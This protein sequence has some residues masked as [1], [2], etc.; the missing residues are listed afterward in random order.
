MAHGLMD[1][2]R[3]V[4]GRRKSK[5]D[6]LRDADR[7]LD[8]EYRALK[9]ERDT[10]ARERAKVVLSG[11]ES[12]VAAFDAHV[13]DVEQRI[14]D[15]ERVLRP[16]MERRIAEARVEAAVANAPYHVEGLRKAVEAVEARR[17]E[18][19]AAQSHLRTLARTIGDDWRLAEQHGQLP[20]LPLV[21]AE[22]QAQVGELLE[23]RI[24]RPAGRV[25]FDAREASGA[26]ETWT[27]PQPR[28][29]PTK[30][31]RFDARPGQWTFVGDWTEEEKVR[32][33]RTTQQRQ[34]AGGIVTG[35]R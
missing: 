26:R 31:V 13:R 16:A 30:F 2:V 23:L 21:P 24:E 25:T 9:Q 14:Q 11:P 4:L 6:E 1:Q 28:T 5:L 7:K 29:A 17:A 19:E 35:S 12:A 3:S 8:Q 33:W 27:L 32:W 10:F 20:A 18:F 34:R 22:M 15:I